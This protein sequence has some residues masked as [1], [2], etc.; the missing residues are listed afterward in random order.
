[1]ENQIRSDWIMQLTPNKSCIK[2]F[3]F[4]EEELKDEGIEIEW[5]FSH[6]SNKALE[7]LNSNSVDF[8]SAAGAA[9]LFRKVNGAPIKNVYISLKT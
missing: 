2:R 7:F 9:H 5:V 3:R 4:L 8:G 1:M 6:G